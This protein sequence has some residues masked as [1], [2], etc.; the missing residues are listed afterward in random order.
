MIIATCRYEEGLNLSIGP[1]PEELSK[2]IFQKNHLK[3]DAGV[4]DHKKHYTCI[5]SLSTQ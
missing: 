1:F 4:I 5:I 3:V 2:T